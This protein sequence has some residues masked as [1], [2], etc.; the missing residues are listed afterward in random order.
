V[1]PQTRCDNECLSGGSLSQVLD[2]PVS[3]A[4][5]ALERH[6]WLEAFDLLQR[7]D[8]EADLAAEDLEAFSEAAWWTAHVEESID[9][10]QRAFNA[11]VQQEDPIHAALTALVLSREFMMKGD[12]ALSGGWFSR[13]ERLLSGCEDSVAHGYLAMAKAMG[14]PNTELEAVVVLSQEA[15]DTGVRYGDKSLQA[16][17]LAIQGTAKVGLGEIEAGLALLDEATI[18]AISGELDIFAT[19][20][21]Y[22]MTISTCRDLA[23]YRRAGE[24]TEAAKRWCERQS[25]NGFPGV[26]RVHRAEI[27]S[28]RGDC[29]LA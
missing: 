11:Y 27:M 7:A 28:L 5:Q 15:L 1:E 20:I 21:I 10:R 14:T 3:L 6:S 18:A 22:C 19:G 9:A 13:A 25:I 8:R 12:Q 26:C 23:D 16:F 29:A 24:W 2:D 17:G 4:R